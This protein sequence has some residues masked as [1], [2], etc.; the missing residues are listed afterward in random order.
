MGQS[1]VVYIYISTISCCEVKCE[2]GCQREREFLGVKTVYAYRDKKCY[3]ELQYQ[4]PSTRLQ[5]Q[6]GHE[7]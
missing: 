6:L 3:F 5:Q 4:L 1:I 2:A 7:K